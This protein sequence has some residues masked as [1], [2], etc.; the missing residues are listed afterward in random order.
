M[1]ERLVRVVGAA[2]AIAALWAAAAFMTGV[3]RAQ[4]LA[5]GEEAAARGRAAL[6]EGL[7]ADALPHIRLAVALD[8]G[9]TAYR[10]DLSRALAEQGNLA[11]A[12]SYLSDVLRQDPVNGSANLAMARAHRRAGRDSE[13]EIFYYRAIYGRWPPEEQTTRVEV[14]LE[15]IALLQGSADRERVR[16]EFTQL[17][18]AFPGDLELQIRVGRSLLELGVADDAARV[19]RAASDRF[20]A[21]GPALK[22]LAEAE[23]IRGD[24]PASLRAARRAIALDPSDADSIRRR[25]LAAR[26]IAIDPTSPRLSAAERIR[27]LRAL[28]DRAQARLR[29]CAPAAVA[30]ATTADLLDSA[31]RTLSARRNLEYSEGL[32]LLE[33][34]ARAALSACAGTT[35]PDDPPTLV[36]RRITAGE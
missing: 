33:A 29:E 36:M 23:F 25:D 35:A 12:T 26:V 2:A 18:A 30:E 20:A 1:N 32:E 27:R 24:Y 8:P 13:A 31:R 14:R 10:L 11:E 15:L 22:A 19:L 5:R 34:L 7:T 9:R 28:I 16:A 3:Y 17:A 21:P 4:K 6:A